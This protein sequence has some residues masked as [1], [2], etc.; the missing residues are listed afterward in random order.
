LTARQVKKVVLR[1]ACT[2]FL[3]VPIQLAAADET[4]P[5]Q[6][7]PSQAS[8]PKDA[9]APVASAAAHS[10]GSW[11]Y[12][13]RGLDIFP[14]GPGKGQDRL[15]IGGIWMVAPMFT[16]DYKRGLGA[17]FNW[18]VGLE[19]IIIYNQLGIGAEWAAPAGPFSLGLMLHFNA[20]YGVLG[21]AVI[22]TTSFDSSGWGLLLDPGVKAGL[23]VAKDSWLTLQMELYL[24]LYQSQKL[25]TL[26]LSPNSASYS[27]F[28]ITLAV[29]Y[30]PKMEGVIYYGVSLYHTAANYPM[31]MNVEASPESDPFTPTMIWYLGLLAGYEF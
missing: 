16:L 13:E 2:A 5:L 21:K 29:E 6:A 30:A 25:G 4:A 1:V 11:Q 20:F 10:E 3:A 24:S 18:D 12:P 14:A 28:G 9:P 22:A 19:S 27:G 17:G 31:W 15:S 7:E 8:L 23:Q 26:T